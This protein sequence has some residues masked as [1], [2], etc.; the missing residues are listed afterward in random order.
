MVHQI[1]VRRQLSWQAAA[2]CIQGVRETRNHASL[3]HALP[4][5]TDT[6]LPNARSVLLG[7]QRQLHLLEEDDTCAGR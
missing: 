6:F 5:V 2:K 7:A 4:D 1:P 3:L